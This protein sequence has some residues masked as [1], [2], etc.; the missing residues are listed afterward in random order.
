MLDLGPKDILRFKEAREEG[1]DK[2]LDGD[3]LIKAIA[4]H[5]RALQRPIVVSGSKA[6][7]G[8]PPESVLDI[9]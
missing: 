7:V 6:A 9:I 3:D 1:I 8:R 2:A 5:P 4:A